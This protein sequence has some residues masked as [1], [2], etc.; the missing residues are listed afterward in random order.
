MAADALVPYM[1]KTSETALVQLKHFL[2]F[3]KEWF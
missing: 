3:F 1:A 2:D